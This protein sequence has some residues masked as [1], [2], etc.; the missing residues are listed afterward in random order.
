MPPEVCEALSPDA[1]HL[2]VAMVGVN[3][4]LEADTLGHGFG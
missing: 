2:L 3:F 1:A 4:W